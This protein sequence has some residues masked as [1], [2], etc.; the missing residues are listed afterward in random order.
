DQE[1]ILTRTWTATDACGNSSTAC[2]QVITITD[3]TAPAITCPADATVDCSP[4][5]G[6][7]DCFGTP[8]TRSRRVSRCHRYRPRTRG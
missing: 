6:S 8:V 2:D 4:A 5:P 7:A 3:S 1:T